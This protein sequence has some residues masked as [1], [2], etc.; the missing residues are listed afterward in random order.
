MKKLLVAASVLAVLTTGLFANG[1]QENAA[2]EK[3][4][5]EVFQFKVEI[6]EQLDALV[7][8][9]EAEN[10]NID[11]V[12][13]TVGG[14]NDYGAALR[15]RM[16]SGEEPAIFNIG[17]QDA[18]TE[19]WDFVE[20]LTDQP[21]VAKSFAGTLNGSSRNENVYGQPYNQEGYGIMYNKAIL[22]QAGYSDSDLAK[23]DT[24]EELEAVF[25]DVEAQ[26]ADL[27]VETVLS[28]SVGGSAWWTASIHS[29]NTVWANQEDPEQFIEDLL[30]G[31]EKMTGNK[32][33]EGYLDMLDVFMNYSYDDLTTIEYNDQVSNFALG[34]TAF[35][36]QGNW[37]IGTLQEIDP[38]IDVAY[39]PHTLG[40]GTYDSIPTGVPMYWS[41]NKNKDANVKEGAK[42]FLD[43]IASTDRGHRFIV[44]ES[45]FIPA[46]EV[47][48]SPSD[49]LARS[50]MDFSSRGKTIGWYW[51]SIPTGFLDSPTSPVVQAMQLYYMNRDRAEFFN[52]IE[53]G[54]ADLIQN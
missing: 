50:I 25:A 13:D 52:I 11:I 33:F 51:G 30:A 44:E 17:G 16:A 42:K 29:F 22:K 37:T 26:K 32:V 28:F 14:G 40:G 23:I 21:W 9:F 39:L 47:G 54:L 43:Y 24:L 38:S 31:K 27:G 3:V 36:H 18:L 10:P 2:E 46:F 49:P 34:K 53:D 15:L 8:D 4:Q 7:A 1:Q 35:L 19:W 6:V 45:N 5:V 48:I 41:V 20:P 12:M